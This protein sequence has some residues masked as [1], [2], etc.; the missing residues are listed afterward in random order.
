[1]LSRYMERA[2]IYHT[3]GG[4][5]SFTYT[6]PTTG[7]VYY[8]FHGNSHDSIDVYPSYTYYENHNLGLNNGS[9]IKTAIRNY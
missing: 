5:V 3:S 7:K 2:D 9:K 4:E 8:R 6:S 1:M